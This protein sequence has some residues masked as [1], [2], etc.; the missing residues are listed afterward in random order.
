MKL[1]PMPLY[2][3]QVEIVPVDRAAIRVIADGQNTAEP[4][5][6]TPT[7][8]I[9]SCRRP[10]TGRRNLP[11]LEE[12]A[13]VIHGKAQRQLAPGQIDEGNTQMQIPI[14]HGYGIN[15]RGEVTA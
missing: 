2:P 6:F 4:R 5:V 11:R 10:S 9:V 13:V 12:F 3:V 7:H 8:K 15:I 14:A 1:P